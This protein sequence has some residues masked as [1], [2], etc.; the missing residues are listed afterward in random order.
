MSKVLMALEII[1]GLQFL[2]ISTERFSE[3]KKAAGSLQ[4]LHTQVGEMLS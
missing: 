3:M 4:A 2:G 1:R